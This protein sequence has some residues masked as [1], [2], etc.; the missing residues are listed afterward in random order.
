MDG[1]RQFLGLFSLPIVNPSATHPT[2]HGCRLQPSGRGDDIP[3]TKRDH[4][5]AERNVNSDFYHPWPL[6]GHYIN[7][8][9][10]QHPFGILSM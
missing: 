4:L 3:S 5:L 6:L 1:F 10:I 8:R 7:G 9:N 2:P